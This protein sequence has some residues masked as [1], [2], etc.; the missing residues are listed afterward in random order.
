MDGSAL[1]FEL[2]VEAEVRWLDRDGGKLCRAFEDRA[3]QEVQLQGTAVLFLQGAR[4][5]SNKIKTDQR[6][7]AKK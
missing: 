1:V 4:A 5:T 2:P 7:L 3:R 6:S